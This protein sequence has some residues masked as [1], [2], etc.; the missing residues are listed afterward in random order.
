MTYEINTADSSYA[1]NSAKSAASVAVAKMR[2]GQQ[3]EAWVITEDADGRPVCHQ[4]AV[5]TVSETARQ[6]AGTQ[7]MAYSRHS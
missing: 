2:T 5:T 1:S 4:V 6:L 3:P 7:R